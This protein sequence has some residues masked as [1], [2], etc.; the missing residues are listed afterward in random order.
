MPIS[1]RLTAIVFFMLLLTPLVGAPDSIQ[2]FG[3]LLCGA[4]ALR[5]AAERRRKSEAGVVALLLLAFIL[6]LLGLNGLFSLGREITAIRFALPGSWCTRFI[7]LDLPR[8]LRR[9]IEPSLWTLLL[10]TAVCAR[11]IAVRERRLLLASSSLIFVMLALESWILLTG[12]APSQVCMAAQYLL[13]SAML[14]LLFAGLLSA[15]V[16]KKPAAAGSATLWPAASLMCAAILFVVVA[17]YVWSGKTRESQLSLGAH[18][19]SWFPENWKAGHVGEVAATP[20]EPLLGKYLS[21]DPSVFGA[22]LEWAK[23][24]GIEFFVFDWWPERK[25]ARNRI[26]RNL[27]DAANMLH[28]FE[29][30]V[31]YETLDLKTT[32]RERRGGEDANVLVI[33]PERADRMRRHWEHIARHYAS[34]PSYM[35][36]EGRPVLFVY[37]SRHVVGEAGRY[38]LW[39]KEAV[40]QETGVDFYL[41]GDE[42][43]FNV[44]DMNAEGKVILLGQQQANWDRLRAFDALTCYNPYDS[45]RSEHA[46]VEGVERFISDVAELYSFYRGVAAASGQRFIPG[47]VPAY[48]DRGVR[49]KAGHYII[50]R[51]DSSGD[52]LLLRALKS[53]WAQGSSADNF[54]TII[55]SWNEWN[56]GT[57]IEPAKHPDQAISGSCAGLAASESY[58]CKYLSELRR[59]SR[60]SHALR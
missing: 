8:W 38:F 28:D 10:L 33:T 20:Y 12:S 47:V 3:V 9:F 48:D 46:G 45:S 13:V 17:C 58:G 43:Y 37:A 4:A 56:E 52:S 15:G 1:V 44:L 41:V 7:V 39:A 53:W 29:F 21:D 35:R 23:E 49:P 34:H 25:S 40:K 32:E 31:Q 27:D 2:A 36:I 54:R 16:Q 24:A 18:Y 11:D 22:H 26:R 55:T 59:F 30:A 5:L 51:T 6:L 60:N 19:Y 42:V 14:T 50:P 57:Q